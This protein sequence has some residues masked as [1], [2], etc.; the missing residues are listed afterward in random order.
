ME[1]HEWYSLSVYY[2]ED[3]QS[4]NLVLETMFEKQEQPN[5]IRMKLINLRNLKVSLFKLIT[6]KWWEKLK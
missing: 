2:F 4:L 6:E 3:E 5:L 1:A